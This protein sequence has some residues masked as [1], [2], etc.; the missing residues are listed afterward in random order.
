MGATSEELLHIAD[1]G[2]LTGRDGKFESQRR[3]IGK[4]YGC[5]NEIREASKDGIASLER[6][7]DENAAQCWID[8]ERMWKTLCE[9]DLPA[10]IAW[11]HQA[12]AGQE[13]V[14]FVFVNLLYP[15]IRNDQASHPQLPSPQKLQVTPQAWMAGIGDTASELSKMTMSLLLNADL[16]GDQR[17][18]IRKRF[19]AVAGEIYYFLDKFE[20]VYGQVINNSRR[21]GFGNTF[22]GVI[23]RV[24]R[25]MEIHQEALVSHLDRTAK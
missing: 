3:N 10:D 5:A 6:G 15:Q 16:N 22:R 25:V 4:A 2:G 12:E 9:L 11:Q 8:M 18:A 21:R 13:Y 19:L 14:E 20:T 24:K 17:V 1:E 7:D 23:H